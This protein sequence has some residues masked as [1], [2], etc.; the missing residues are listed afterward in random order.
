[1]CPLSTVTAEKRRSSAIA[2]TPSDVVQPHSGAAANSGTWPNTT[3]GVSGVRDARSFA[4][5]R[6]LLVAE[7]PIVSP[8]PTL[9]SARKW[10]PP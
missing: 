3:M 6:D 10:I 1:M 4:H 5:P 7:L 2:L 8:S 9:I